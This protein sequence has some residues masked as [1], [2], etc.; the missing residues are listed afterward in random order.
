[1]GETQHP[2]EAL[3]PYGHAGSLVY[4]PR[5]GLDSAVGTL[6]TSRRLEDG[7]CPG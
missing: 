6:E 3:P 5:E 2:I 4:I 1:M 7:M